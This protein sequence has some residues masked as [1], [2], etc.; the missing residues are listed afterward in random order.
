M[1]RFLKVLTNGFVFYPLVVAFCIAYLYFMS[2]VGEYFF[3][4]DYTTF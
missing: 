3:P 4:T 2:F 1:S